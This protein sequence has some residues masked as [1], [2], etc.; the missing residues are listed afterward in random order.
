MNLMFFGQVKDQVFDGKLILND[1]NL[2]LDFNGL[3]DF[4]DDL[5]DFDF[6]SSIRYANLFNLGF[7]DIGEVYGDIIVKLRGNNMDDLIGDLTL[8]KISYKKY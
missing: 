3:I 4:S 2:N 6:N 8:K 1:S 5:V 7:N